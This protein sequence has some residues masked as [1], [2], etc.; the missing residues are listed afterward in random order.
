MQLV[1]MCSPIPHSK[2]D[3]LPASISSPLA[4][5]P[6]LQAKPIHCK[7][8]YVLLQKETY[9]IC[10]FLQANET[11]FYSDG[12]A[13]HNGAAFS[14]YDQ[15]HDTYGTGSC[16]TAGSA[17]VTYSPG[18]NWFYACWQQFLMGQE[19]GWRKS[20]IFYRVGPSPPL[21]RTPNQC[22][23]ASLFFTGSSFFFAG[24][25]SSSKKKLSF[26]HFY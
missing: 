19:L 24:S 12:F 3:P 9:H 18:P 1:Q 23:R 20:F 14:T 5:F 26:N 21:L 16:A 10:K 13:Y 8:E 4:E 25:S 6:F 17:T 15:D 7:Y 11:F 2:L 22:C